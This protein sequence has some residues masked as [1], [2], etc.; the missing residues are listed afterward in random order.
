M[1]YPLWIPTYGMILFC[2]TV[3]QTMP[4]PWT[5]WLIMCGMTLLLT[6]IL[7]V[8][9][10]LYQVKRGLIDDIYIKNREQRTLAYVET[11]M[12]FACWWYL[13]AF[14]VHAPHWLC[15]AALGGTIAIALVAVINRW[16]KISA[17]LTGMGGLL[18]GIL[19]YG[20]SMFS[21]PL[22]T[23][24]IVLSITLLVMYARL[25]LDAHTDSQVI[26]GFGLGMVCVL[27]SSIL[28]A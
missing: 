23:L 20:I 5:Y 19:A 11:V 9:L 15:G 6:G 13:L 8:S 1:F 22:S 21:F 12:G 28:Y 14:I 16:W 18:G 26:A 7:P 4:L 10:I 24:V 25:W 27:V 17:H 2:A 3:Q